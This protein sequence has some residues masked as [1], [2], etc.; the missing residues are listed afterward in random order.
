MVSFRKQGPSVLQREHRSFEC[1]ANLD[2]T[3]FRVLRQG[4][5]QYKGAGLF[6]MW[7]EVFCVVGVDNAGGAS[8]VI[9]ESV[10]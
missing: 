3:D 2:S 4:T 7:N 5:L 9:Y 8:L 1:L 6:D 10:S